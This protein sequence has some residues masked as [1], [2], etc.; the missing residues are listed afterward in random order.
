MISTVQ[1]TGA[2]FCEEISGAVDTSFNRFYEGNPPSR[3]IYS[4]E[5]FTLL[6]DMSPLAVGH[7]LLL[8]KKHYLSFA[9]VFRGHPGETESLVGQVTRLYAETFREPLV[10]EHGS[11]ANHESHACITHAHLH[12]LPVDGDAVDELMIADGL[13]HLD[14]P[15]PAA[16]GRPPWPDSAYFLRLYGGHCR[17]Y[18]P[19]AGQRRQYLR[20]VA[21][22]TLSIDDPEWDYAVVMRK[23]A[24][25]S[26]MRTVEHWP[27]RLGSPDATPKD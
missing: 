3:R 26:T 9:Q 19:T 8:P 20:S 16:L 21:G 5:K 22:T 6:A 10:M 11:T 18:L 4:S 1:C 23:E 14:L 2:D 12:F 25:R 15:S 24:L 27:E 17:V 13:R 7:L